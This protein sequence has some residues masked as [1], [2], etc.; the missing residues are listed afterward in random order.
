[1][2]AIET[3]RRRLRRRERVTALATDGGSAKR[4]T[5]AHGDE[6]CRLAAARI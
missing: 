4:P 5:V 1:M 6:R 3:A 2:A